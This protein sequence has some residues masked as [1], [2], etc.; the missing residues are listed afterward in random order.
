MKTAYVLL[1]G[2]GFKDGSEIHEAVLCLLAL[3]HHN[4]NVECLAPTIPQAQVINHWKNTTET[5]ERTAIVEAAR[6]A[7]GSI[8][9]LEQ[10]TP[11]ADLLVIPGGI[12]AA[13]TLCT[14]A[15]QKEKASVLP[16]VHKLISH[17]FDHKK[18]IVA[19]CIAPVLLAL[20]L[21]SKASLTM[22]LGTNSSDLNWLK[23][24]GM[25]PQPCSSD[26]YITDPNHAIIT[27]PAYM[28]ETTISKMWKGISGAIEHAISLEV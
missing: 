16:E 14:Y 3:D 23:T 8:H 28:E 7:R 6:I 9:P 13:T 21:H 22:T 11:Q 27:T 1:S 18:P 26:T 12:G 20:T 2:C 10:C 25:Q 15:S 5:Q 19:T 4:I 24:M 17:F